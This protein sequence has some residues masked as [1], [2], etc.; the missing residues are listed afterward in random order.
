MFTHLCVQY[1]VHPNLIKTGKS[2]QTSVKFKSASRCCLE[3]TCAWSFGA[4][5]NDH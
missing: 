2:T 3:M 1:I 5:Q 4:D